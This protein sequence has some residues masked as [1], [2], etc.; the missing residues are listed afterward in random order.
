MVNVQD[1]AVKQQNG[2]MYLLP[3]HPYLQQE[4]FT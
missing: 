4:Y 3:R 1:A 2:Q